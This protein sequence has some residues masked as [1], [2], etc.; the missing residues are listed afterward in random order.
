[1][2]ARTKRYTYFIDFDHELIITQ[3]YIKNIPSAL[4][5]KFSRLV[6]KL[7][8][9]IIGKKSSRWPV[10]WSLTA[11]ILDQLTLGKFRSPSIILEYCTSHILASS[12]DKAIDDTDAAVESTNE[13]LGGRYTRIVLNLLALKVTSKHKISHLDCS[14]RRS[15]SDD[16]VTQ[17]HFSESKIKT[18]QPPPCEYV[19]SHLCTAYIIRQHSIG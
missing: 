19:L 4:R 12:S 7:N 13:L 8:E 17:L 3:H 10:E 18:Q 14:I 16:N 2:V 9:T 6:N 5:T 15:F 1:M 11:L